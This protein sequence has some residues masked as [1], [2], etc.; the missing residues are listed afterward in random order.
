MAEDNTQ[1]GESGAL[2]PSRESTGFEIDTRLNKAI[3]AS[4]RAAE[5]IRLDAEEQAQEHL[6]EAQKKADRLTAERVRLTADLTTDLV[7]RAAVI[8]SHSE[9]LTNALEEALEL[10]DEDDEPSANAPSAATIPPAPTDTDPVRR[11]EVSPSPAQPD[12]KLLLRVTQLAIAGYSRASIAETIL[13]ESGEDPSAAI[14]QV[15]E[16]RV[17]RG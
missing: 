8:R 15:F 2:E 12:Q 7:N 10:V 9:Q 4:E 1:S 13:S 6:I 11:P 17:T 3:E 5:A 14:E 16:K